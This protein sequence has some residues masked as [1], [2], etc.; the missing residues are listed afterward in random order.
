MERAL[1]VNWAGAALFIGTGLGGS[2]VLFFLGDGCSPAQSCS[3]FF[4]QLSALRLWL[5]HLFDWKEVA[6]LLV[7]FAFSAML[8][9][10]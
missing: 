9:A 5:C 4:I 10:V 6:V 2:N 8:T 1:V 7:S 3:S